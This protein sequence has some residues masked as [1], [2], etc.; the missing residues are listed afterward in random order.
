MVVVDRPALLAGDALGERDALG[1]R[2]VRELR[3]AGLVEGDHVADRGDARHARL[4][5][6]RRPGCS[7]GPSRGPASSAP[8][9]FVT[10]PRPVATSRYSALDLRGLAVGRLRLE[11]DAAAP[12]FAP[13]TFVPVSTLMPCF[14]KERSSSAETASSSTGTM[15]RQQ[16][17]DRHVA[18]EAAEDRRE[19]DADRAAAHDRRSTSGLLHVDR[20][21]AGDDALAIDL[22]SGHAAR[23]ANRW[24]R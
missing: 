19:L 22:D 11:V 13:V 7:R 14:L 6:A 16:L 5:L 2:E 15:P 18:A 3:V 8:S 4:V 10:G 21:V 24:R 20:L 1:R 17:D 9:P 23:R 12:A